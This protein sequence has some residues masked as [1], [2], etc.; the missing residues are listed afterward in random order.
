MGLTAQS[1]GSGA[2]DEMIEIKKERHDDII[3]GLAGNPNTGKSTVFNSLTGLKQHTGNWPGKTV[4]N[5]QGRYI[6]GDRGYV[7]V[8]L[9]GTYSLL[10]NSVEE[11]VARDFI[12]FGNPHVTVVVTDA[13]SLQRNLNLVLQIL[14]MTKK[15]VV[16]VNLMDEAERKR[17]K[18]DI[19]ELS[20]ILGVPVVATSARCGH[21]LTQLKDA[22][23]RVATGD[24]PLKGYQVKYQDKIEESIDFVKTYIDKLNLG[25]IDSRWAGLR[26]IEG[27][28]KLMNS[29]KE[30]IGFTTEQERE[31]KKTI[32]QGRE[33]LHEEQLYGDS[34]HDSMVSSIVKTA[35]SIGHKVV[36]FGNKE[37]NK[38]DHRVDKILTSKTWGIPIMIALLGLILWITIQGAN[39]PSEVLAKGLFWIEDHLTNFFMWMG[40]PQWLHGILVLGVYRTLAWVISVMLPPMAIFFPL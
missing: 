4:S 25:D 37:Y 18:V 6:H 5:A 7:L 8:D 21:G 29:I 39:Y 20:N 35:E 10:S 12:C 36:Y 23:E 19:E 31:L 17:I 2:L 40:T 34:L 13:T 15:A 33:H 16:C 27:N 11:E 1:T 24:Y 14:E 9:P 30:Y 32:D 3:V 38:F 22:I 28:E 26:L